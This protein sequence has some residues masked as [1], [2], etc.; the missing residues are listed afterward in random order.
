VGGGGF[1]AV[2]WAWL[3]ATA[4]LL[5]C[6]QAALT[7]HVDLPPDEI[8]PGTGSATAQATVTL[9]CQQALLRSHGL[10]APLSVGMAA[11]TPP[12]VT[13]AGDPVLDLPV[14]P[15]RAGAATTQA[16]APYQVG[17]STQAPAHRPLAFNLTAD[18][19]QDPMAGPLAPHEAQSAALTARAKAVVLATVGSPQ[20]VH[21]TRENQTIAFQLS[22]RGNTPV[23]VTGTLAFSTPLAGAA[24]AT[25]DLGSRWVA[26][27]GPDNAT[28]EFTIHAPDKLLVSEFTGHAAF[29]VVA[30]EG[31]APDQT[32]GAELFF[33][34]EIPA[35]KSSPAPAAP[36]L[37]LGLLAFACL[38]RR[39]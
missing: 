31:G 15:C 3:A 32:I 16:Q 21:L 22:N 1:G 33:R 19:P 12:E 24:P 11:G 5:P 2:R 4:V 30:T 25:V 10:D 18:L 9:D 28:V 14:A 36:L 17:V 20:A 39:A 37:G 13:V 8:L 27:S 26:G 34:D 38:R 6:A 7:L 23:R 35:A 29:V